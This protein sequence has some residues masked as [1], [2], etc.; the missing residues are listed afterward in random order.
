[1]AGSLP[2]QLVVANTYIYIYLYLWSALSRKKGT[3]IVQSATT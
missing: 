2:D 1:M 3:L